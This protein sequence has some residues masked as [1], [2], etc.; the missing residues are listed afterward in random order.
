[1]TADLGEANGTL[2][3]LRRSQG[4]S[5]LDVAADLGV[6]IEDLHALSL[7]E[8]L[9]T[10]SGQADGSGASVSPALRVVAGAERRSPGA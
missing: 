9:Y 5:S 3:H 8:A 1:L 6:T 7:G 4:L 2:E 10:V